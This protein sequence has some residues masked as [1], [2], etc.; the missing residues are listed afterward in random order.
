MKQ[1]GEER[2]PNI[3]KP[4]AIGKF[5]TKNR[6][7]YGACCVSNYNDRDGTIT[8]RELART[9]IITQT[10]SG[11]ITNQG[12]FPD[13]KGEG[14]SYY[15]QI[16]L[17]DDRFL[18]QFEQIASWIHEAG[19]VA[20]QQILHTGR[21]GGVD[22]GYCVQPS[23]VPQ[24]LPHF[25]PPREMTKDEIKQTLKD[26]AAASARAI[27]AGFDG[28]EI[29]SF[30]GYLLANFLSKFTNKRTDEY[31]GSLEKRAR[32]MREL[33]YVI[34]EAI[35]DDHV[36][37]ARLNGA[38]LMDRYGGN[39]EDECLETMKIAAEC[40]ID[41]ISIT[42][43][44]QESPVSSIGRDVPPGHWLYLAERAKREIPNVPIA[45]GVRMAD[46][47]MVE[48]ALADG[49]F[50]FWEVCRPFLADP[51]RLIKV[52]ENR[53]EDIRP[54]I[55]CNFCLSRLF[56]D[57]PYLCTMNPMLGHEVEAEYHLK[58]AA[59]RKRVMVVGGGPA[60]MEYA[61]NAAQR[62]HE[63]HLYEAGDK[64]GGQL[65]IYADHDLAHPEDLHR[66]IS[67]Y[68]TQ[69]EKQGVQ[70]HLNTV[71]TADLIRSL[72]PA[73]I[74]VVVVAAGSA[75]EKDA[76][77]PGVERAVIAH[78]VLDG[79]VQAGKKVAVIGGGKIGLV[80]AESLT[81]KGHEV[82]ILEEGRRISEDVMPTWKWRHSQWVE[83]L[84][85]KVL[86][87]V[88][89]KQITE[90]G[91]VVLD[92]NGN[93]AMVAADTV[94]WATNRKSRQDLFHQ[95]EFMADETHIVGDA[96]APRGLHN[97]IHDGYKLGVRV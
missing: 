92:K 96:V 51:Q 29:T 15:R 4:G 87:Q 33:I 1:T 55:S 57:I 79:R 28:V 76:R 88:K 6:V 70:V 24:T 68:E 52:R 13:A 69:L 82:T 59:Y 72:T 71:V 64:L 91:V 62:G 35:G 95:A 9:R 48:K 85:I 32:F 21:Y 54:C 74:D 89:I 50:D 30:M 45:F 39:T 17:Y 10:G 22:L 25:R 60:G 23:A 47:E 61:I 20:I 40:G 77:I 41:M 63:V 37:C 80:T 78:D 90:H 3:F 67:Y 14:K 8:P 26:H 66:V 46:T 86:T 75:P 5:P 2:F 81:K 49:K 36:L 27:K 34:K 53:L 31:G 42:V 44:W 73:D 93:E 43:G 18:P 12:A 94:I 16:A 97:A 38:E 65:R 7:K 56:R 84:N 19:A 58:P 83:D 11:I